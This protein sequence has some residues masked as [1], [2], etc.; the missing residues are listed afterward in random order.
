MNEMQLTYVF[1]AQGSGFWGSGKHFLGNDIFSL[2][3]CPGILPDWFENVSRPN[4]ILCIKYFVKL[5]GWSYY[6]CDR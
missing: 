4:Q 6:D 2:A 5:K 3:F 1:G